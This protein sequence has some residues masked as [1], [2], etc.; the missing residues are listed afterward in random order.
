MEL[1][2]L[3]IVSLILAGCGTSPEVHYDTARLLLKQGKL[4][5]AMREAEAGWRAEPS[6]RFRILKAD[7][8]LQRGEAKAA[9]ELLTSSEPP[10]DPES[11]ARL[12]MD[13]GWA[14]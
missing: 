10:S 6:W 11:R 2:R 12:K 3:A 8:L 5:E 14:E 9:K 4:S 7:V 13:E 1:R